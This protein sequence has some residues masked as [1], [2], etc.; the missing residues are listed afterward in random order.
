VG[1][2]NAETTI[3]TVDPSAAV[4]PP[5]GFCRITSPFGAVVSVLSSTSTS[6]PAS[7]RIRSASACISPTT[8]GTCS[9]PSEK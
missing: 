1:S 9:G 6:K 2:S 5:G 7:V 8:S 3:R 4:E